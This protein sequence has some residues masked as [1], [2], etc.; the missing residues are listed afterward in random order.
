MVRALGR[1]VSLRKVDDCGLRT[2]MKGGMLVEK[3]G[4]GMRGV[5]GGLELGGL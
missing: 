3:V 1:V 5:L 2:A 4:R